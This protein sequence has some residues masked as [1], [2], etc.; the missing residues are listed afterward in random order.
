MPTGPKAWNGGVL[1]GNALFGSAGLVSQRFRRLPR[2][3]RHRPAHSAL[4][5]PEQLGSYLVCLEMPI[6]FFTLLPRN[7]G[8]RAADAVSVPCRSMLCQCVICHTTLSAAPAP[9]LPRHAS[10]DGMTF[11]FRSQGIL[12]HLVSSS[13]LISSIEIRPKKAKGFTRCRKNGSDFGNDD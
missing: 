8:N 12:R 1:S 11:R 3:W 9:A 4:Q 2:D 7:R 5:L 6:E 10:S 13:G